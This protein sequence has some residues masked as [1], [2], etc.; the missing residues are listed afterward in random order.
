MIR[1]DK[2]KAQLFGGVGFRQ[3]TLSGYDIVDAANQASQ[4]DKYFQDSSRLVTIKNIKE[5]QE[6]KD[7]TNEQ[8]NDL[9]KQMQESVIEDVCDKITQKESDFI[10]SQNLYPFEKT[11]NNTLEVSNKFNGF[12]I[13][14]TK[15]QEVITRLSFI[16]LAFD[17]AVT[18]NIYLYNS[19]KPNGAI[20]TQVVTTIANESVIVALD[21]YLADN[22]AHK[23]GSYYVGY[24]EDDLAGAKPIKRDYELST[25]DIS[26]RCNYILPVKLDHTGNTIDV[27]TYDSQSDTGGL[28]I[29]IETY[30][31]YT[32]LLI[33]NKNILWKAIQT[34]MGIKVLDMI[35]YSTRVNSDQRNLQISIQDINLELHG[36]K[37]EHTVIEGLLKKNNR[38]ISDI[39]QTL[40]PKSRIYTGTLL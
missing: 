10:Q 19:N 11:F 6:N 4:S 26:S 23:G 5:T 7:I 17:S 15:R 30:S 8:F 40:F 34:E 31:D 38:N 20:Q 37:D 24:F 14:P 12:R 1:S 28:N 32:D 39:K 29:G 16:E 2:I 36:F 25:L 18:F 22:E 13:E 21:W 3:P 27:S 35:K 9:L 33:R